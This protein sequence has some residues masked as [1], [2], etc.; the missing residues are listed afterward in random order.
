MDSDDNC[1]TL[2]IYQKPLNCKLYR[3]KKQSV[4]GKENI[5]QGTEEWDLSF[6]ECVLGTV[7]MTDKETGPRWREWW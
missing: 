5:K 2:C 4:A 3:V 6:L 1:T 7:A